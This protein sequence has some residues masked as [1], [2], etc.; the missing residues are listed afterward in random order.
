MYTKRPNR[1]DLFMDGEFKVATNGQEVDGNV[2]WTKPDKSNHLP[3]IG[4]HDAGANFFERDNQ[5]FHFIISGRYT[6]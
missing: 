1:I 4:S 5:M 2:E 3:G 6:I